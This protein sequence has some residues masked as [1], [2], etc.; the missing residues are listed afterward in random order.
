MTGERRRR[1][2][3]TLLILAI[4]TIASGV[5]H[6]MYVSAFNETLHVADGLKDTEDTYMDLHFRGD[7]TSAWVKQD[8]D[9]YGN[10]YDGALYN[11]STYSISSWMLRINIIGDCYINQFYSAFSETV[12]VP[13]IA[14][15]INNVITVRMTPTISEIQAIL[16]LRRFSQM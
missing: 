16:L 15:I 12:L 4:L 1:L 7:A 14:L 6:F 2:H 11:K 3:I 10:T 8:L 13:P 5:A 9:I